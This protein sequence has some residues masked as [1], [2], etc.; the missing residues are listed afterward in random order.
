MISKETVQGY[1]DDSAWARG[2]AWALYGYTMMYRE[3]GIEDFFEQAVKVADMLLDKLPEDG[4]PYWDFNAPGAPEGLS[5][6]Y[7]PPVRDASAGAIMASAFIE[8]S[9]F[10]GKEEYLEM[11][12]TQLL[13]LGSDEYLAKPGENGFFLLKHSVGSYPEGRDIDVAISYADYY[14]LEALVRYSK[15]PRHYGCRTGCRKIIDG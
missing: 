3:T 10:T 7:C 6:A 14:F 11:A 5:D 1:S 13:T 8:L 9:T 4:I 2:Q 12:R 15:T